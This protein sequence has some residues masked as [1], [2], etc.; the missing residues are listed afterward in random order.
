MA[1]RLRKGRTYGRATLDA[2]LREVLPAAPLDRVLDLGSKDAPYRRLLAARRYDRLDL[3]RSRRPAVVGDAH[4]LPFRDGAYELV[5]ATQ[6]LEHCYN[7]AAVVAEVHRVLRSGG[8]FVC[9][10]P[11][12]YVIHGDP[13]DYWRFTAEGLR[14]LLRDFTQVAIWPLGNRWTAIWDLIAAR[15]SGLKY[16]NY[17][18]HLAPVLARPN[19]GC[20]H[21]Y[22]ALAHKG[23][24]DKREGV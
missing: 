1:L 15:P 3:S 9:S 20:P 2:K 13:D 19:P 4:R 17:L 10:V 11:F 23:E 5:L 8:L 12:I 24:T 18:L 14:H 21:G 16:A 6:V 7:P 22:L